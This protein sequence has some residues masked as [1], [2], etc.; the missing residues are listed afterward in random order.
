MGFFSRN[1]DSVKGEQPAAAPPAL[2]ATTT[3]NNAQ[4]PQPSPPQ[5]QQQQQPSAADLD[6]IGG[7][8]IAGGSQPSSPIG[9]SQRSAASS[10]SSFSDWPRTSQELIDGF[11]NQA[12]VK[13]DYVLGT[14]AYAFGG[15]MHVAAQS[16]VLATLSMWT[17]GTCFLMNAQLRKANGPT[18][19][20]FQYEFDRREKSRKCKKN[21][22]LFLRK[23]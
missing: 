2:P 12:H 21:I 1:A 23:C 10:S 15:A 14:A 6:I 17:A 20:V 22:N 13:L 9:R 18:A 19:D 5:Q 3:S 4:R 11:D 8:H 16:T 7:A